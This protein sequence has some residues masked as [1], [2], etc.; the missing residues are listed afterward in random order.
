VFK[1]HP[2]SLI[3]WIKAGLG[4]LVAL[5]C[6]LIWAN[7]ITGIGIGAMAYILSD[8][9]LRQMFIERVDKPSTVTKTGI[10]IYILTWVF[11]WALLFTLLNAPP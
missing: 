6:V 4:I 7:M 11:F 1:S 8:K 10:G 9:I 5:I 2:L 3:Y